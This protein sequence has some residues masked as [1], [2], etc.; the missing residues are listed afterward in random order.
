[1]YRHASWKQFKQF[2]AHQT[3]QQDHKVSCIQTTCIQL[4]L[5]VCVYR[6][7]TQSSSEQDMMSVDTSNCHSSNVLAHQLTQ[8]SFSANTTNLYSINSPPNGNYG[9]ASSN[10]FSVTSSEDL[11]QPLSSPLHANEQ[12]RKSQFCAVLSATEESLRWENQCSDEEK[13]R[14]RI[15]VYKSNRRKRYKRHFGELHQSQLNPF[16][17]PSE[18]IS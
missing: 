2:R 3:I 12:K 6:V 13:E 7:T 9:V 8:D 5:H 18:S 17:T 10:S 15:E 1:M 11:T 4:L 14:K 16:Y